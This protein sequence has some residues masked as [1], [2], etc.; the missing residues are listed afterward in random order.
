MTIDL[1]DVSLVWIVIEFDEG[2]RSDYTILKVFRER[3]KAYEFGNS[4][5]DGRVW[6]VREYTIID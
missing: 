5:S 3:S 4:L 6:Q 2:N 1:M